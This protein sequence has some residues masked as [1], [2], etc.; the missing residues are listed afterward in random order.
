S[1]GGARWTD[2]WPRWTDSDARW[3]DFG[4]RW[5]DS[6]PVWTDS[7]M[8]SRTDSTRVPH[9][10]VSGRRPVHG[11]TQRGAES[12]SLRG[13]GGSEA[14]GRHV[15]CAAPLAEHDEDAALDQVA[16]DTERARFAH[17]EG[18]LEIGR[19]EAPLLREEVPNERVR[20]GWGCGLLGGHEAWRQML[21][22]N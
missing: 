3:T 19:R 10:D 18:A 14:G 22:L 17:A 13:E 20:L 21:G 16:H 6:L 9:G 12:G 7:P 8:A 2:F 15:E 4:A 11:R 1:A 5:T